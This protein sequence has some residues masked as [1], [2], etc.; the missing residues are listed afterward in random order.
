MNTQTTAVSAARALRFF[1]NELTNPD[2][3]LLILDASTIKLE[4]I[5]D[6]ACYSVTVY[7]RANN[8]PSETKM[9]VVADHLASSDEGYRSAPSAFF[10]VPGWNGVVGTYNNFSGPLRFWA[11]AVDARGNEVVR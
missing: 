10:F 11:G 5:D 6:E 8:G 2:F 7:S 9:F 3:K 4:T 1:H